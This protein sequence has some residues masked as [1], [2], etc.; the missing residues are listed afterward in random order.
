MT[1]RQYRSEVV[2]SEIL[3]LDRIVDISL[4]EID[5]SNLKDANRCHDGFPVDS[6]LELTAENGEISHH[7]VAKRSY[8]KH[9]PPNEIDY[10]AYVDNPDQS[11]FFAYVDNEIAGELVMRRWWN[12]FAYIEDLSVRAKFRRRGVGRTLIVRGISWAKQR[13][14]PGVMLETQNDNVAACR[15]YESSGFKL[16]GFDRYLYRALRPESE[17]IALYWYLLFIEPDKLPS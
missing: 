10:E 7:A 9:Y 2:N 11:V 13:G 15:L 12:N 3:G 5:R 1:S 4:K 6:I 8:E 16:G 14:L 17:E